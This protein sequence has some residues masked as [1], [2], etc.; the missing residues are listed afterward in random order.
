MRTASVEDGEV[1]TVIEEQVVEVDEDGRE[2]ITSTTST[3]VSAPLKT[4]RKSMDQQYVDSEATVESEEKDDMVVINAVV[5]SAGVPSAIATDALSPTSPT[6]PYL[7]P[8][9][10]QAVSILASGCAFTRYSLDG[11]GNIASTHIY[12]FLN[13]NADDNNGAFFYNPLKVGAS[14]DEQDRTE[15]ADRCLKLACLTDVFIGQ[16]DMRIL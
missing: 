5:E 9:V 2:V 14:K 13:I 11:A 4:P 8:S 10:L 15:S 7:S 16:S 6:S 3:V 12:L 1:E